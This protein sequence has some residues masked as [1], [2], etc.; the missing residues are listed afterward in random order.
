ME[1]APFRPGQ[2]LGQLSKMIHDALVYH[3]FSI[4]CNFEAQ[5]PLYENGMVKEVPFIQLCTTKFL[6]GNNIAFL[7]RTKNAMTI[8]MYVKQM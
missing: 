8:I 5:T 6:S 7:N 2:I 1:Q 4:T 3:I